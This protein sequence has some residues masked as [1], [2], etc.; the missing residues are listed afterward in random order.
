[1]EALAR[2]FLSNEAPHLQFS[3]EAIQALRSH[4]W[5]GNVREL[6]NSVVKAALM[7]ECSEILPGDFPMTLPAAAPDHRPAAR[8][9]EELEQQAIMKALSETGGRQDRAAQDPRNLAAN[10]DPQAEGL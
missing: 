1:M 8:T 10:P 4:S 6:R 5:P 2:H 7:A 9:L 3:R